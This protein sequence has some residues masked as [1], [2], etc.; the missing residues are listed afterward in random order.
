MGDN[1]RI[2]HY[3]NLMRLR[4]WY[5]NLVVFLPLIFASDALSMNNFFLTVL[6][7][8]SLSLI[9]SA[10]Y[11]LNDFYDRKKDRL[12]PEKKNRPL[13]SRKVTTGEA[14][15]LIALALAGSTVIA[16]QLSVLFQISILF[17]FLATQLYTLYLKRI[18][19]ADV[20]AI[21]INFVIR[22]V[23]GAFVIKVLISPW[24]ILCPFFLALMMATGKRY[25]DNSILKK[26]AKD[27]NPVLKFYGAEITQSMIIISASALLLSYSLYSFTRTHLM[28]VT[29]PF[30]VYAI[31][32]YI[33]LIREDTKIARNP[34]LLYKD[35][36]LVLAVLL[37]GLSV[38]VILHFIDG[39]IDFLN[40]L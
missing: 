19:F 12:H 17:L 20:L 25:A 16:S 2:I 36:H 33:Y 30:T 26:A 9:S 4:Q 40:Y 1:V 28:I 6:G 21:A 15:F 34:E 7:F 3:I 5:K 39:N 31:F 13:A 11:V 35:W 32:R 27:F 22:V 18:P 38:I 10:N 23:S 37:W 24:I 29:V 8:F 14:F